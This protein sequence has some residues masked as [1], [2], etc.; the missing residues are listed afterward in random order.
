MHATSGKYENRKS[1]REFFIN[2]DIEYK[3]APFTTY[4]KYIDHIPPARKVY[5][6]SVLD[7]GD[8]VDG[9]VQNSSCMWW[10]LRFRLG[11][12]GSKRL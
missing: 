6:R 1:G 2:E 11:S 9:G 10:T 5:V 8:I 3:P 4:S 7:G 12:V